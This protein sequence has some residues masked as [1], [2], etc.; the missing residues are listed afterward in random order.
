MERQDI[1]RNGEVAAT[2]RGDRTPG[3]RSSCTTIVELIQEQ[4]PGD[5]I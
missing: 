2:A 3:V 1:C 5:V 4:R